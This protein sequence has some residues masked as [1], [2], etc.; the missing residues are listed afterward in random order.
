MQIFT[1]KIGINRCYIIK[2]EGIVLIDAGSPNKIDKFQKAF[3]RLKIDPAEI[4][5]IILTHGD[6]DHVGSAKELKAITGAKIAIHHHDKFNLENSLFNFPSG[7]T[8]WG[9]L[10][11]FILS[12][13]L[14]NVI[15]KFPP[16]KADIVL[17]DKNYPLIEYGIHGNIVYTPGHTQGSISVLLET[18]EAFVGCMAHNNPPFRLRPG[19]PIFAEDIKK[20]KASW[21]SIIHPGV[22]TIYPAHGDPFSI[23]IIE[24]VLTKEFR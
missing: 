23:D 16:V 3:E 17:D 5:L 8:A 1:I 4:N 22:K 20:V 12:P 10:L 6:P 21:K 13:V 14:K 9:K 19:L 2:D 18:G 7:V 24:N 11:R 15:P